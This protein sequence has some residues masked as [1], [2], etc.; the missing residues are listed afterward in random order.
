[1]S[2]SPDR[3]AAAAAR[4]RAALDAT[5]AALT[6]PNLDALLAAEAALTDAFPELSYL[7]TLDDIRVRALRDE[8]VAAQSALHR[9]QRLGASLGDVVRISLQAHGH[10]AGYDPARV[11]AATLA[12]RGFQT[13][14]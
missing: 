14:A 8:L 9:A 7:R 3:S 5:A 10:A 4:L 6:E 2:Q 11:A 1:V 12:G 13:R